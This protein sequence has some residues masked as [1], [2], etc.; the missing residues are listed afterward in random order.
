VYYSGTGLPTVDPSGFVA[1]QI[2]MYDIYHIVWQELLRGPSDPFRGKLVRYVMT[3]ECMT[4]IWI[5]MY[6]IP[7]DGMK[8]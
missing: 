6:D 8:G 1:S 7:W 2:V 5:I 3:K 4:H